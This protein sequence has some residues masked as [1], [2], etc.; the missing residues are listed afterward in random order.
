MPRDISALVFDAYGT[1]FDVHS[2]ARLAESLFPGKGAAISTAWRG[3]QLEY[4]WLR[5]LM[6]RYED[7]NRVTN[8]SLAWALES[9]GIDPDA[10]DTASR[11]LIDEYRKLAMFPEVPAALAAL[12]QRVPL[13]ILS[14]GHPEMLEAVVDHNGVRERFRGGILSVHKARMFKPAPEVY[15]LAE[16]ALG[17][18]RALMGF[19][20]S[21]GWDAAG[22]KTFGFRVFWI[23]RS[24][25]PVER[26]GVRPD[27]VVKSLA[28]IEQYLD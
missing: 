12:S 22:A 11:A 9:A 18:P 4:T 14:N 25:A 5:S 1:L 6:D 15:A 28:E 10:N 8:A 24:G 26:L 3:K 27:A 2:V 7:F 16:D 13:A 21:N 20:S 19:V 23:N 17:V